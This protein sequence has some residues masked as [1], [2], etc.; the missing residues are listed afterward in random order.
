MSAKPKSDNKLK[1]TLDR[2]RMSV[3]SRRKV[4]SIGSPNQGSYRLFLGWTFQGKK[5]QERV[6]SCPV[7][8][9]QIRK[10][11]NLLVERKDTNVEKH[12]VDLSS[13]D[14]KK[15]FELLKDHP[16][17]TLVECVQYF[18]DRKGN[19][20]SSI[21]IGEAEDVY[22]GIQHDSNTKPSSWDMNHTN[23]KTYFKPFFEHFSKVPLV[24]LTIEDAQA[25]FTRP[26]CKDWSDATWMAHRRRLIAFWRTMAKHKYCNINHNPFEAVTSK[27]LRASKKNVMSAEDVRTLFVWMEDLCQKTPS[28]YPELALMVLGFFCGIRVEE[29]GRVSWDGLNKKARKLKNPDKDFSGWSMTVWNETEKMEVTK[30]NP[31][32]DNAKEWL[33]LCEANWD[34][35]E[36]SKAVEENKIA[37]K[38]HVQRMKRQVRNPFR[39]EKEIEVE[40]NTARISFTTHHYAFHGDKDLTA[41]RLGHGES[42]RTIERHYLGY[43]NEADAESYFD[44]YPMKFGKGA[45]L[46]ASKRKQ[47]RIV[48]LMNQHMVDYP[49]SNKTNARLWA[50]EQVNNE[51]KKLFK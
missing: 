35:A 43:A 44:I 15:A 8:A 16:G 26:R 25:W 13:N 33:K 6:G 14:T 7:F 51:F 50:K 20:D 10:A 34:N 22:S 27:R 4:D 42:G 29:I 40:Q 11:W 1:K 49:K 47:K 36:I 23:W 45:K 21:T 19:P 12:I 30:V 3:K 39:K 48:E 41:K 17:V 46:L 31:I 37:A 2:L 28:R 38:D 18:L 9:E 24:D 32:P 5:V